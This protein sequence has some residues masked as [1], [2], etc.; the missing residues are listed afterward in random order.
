ME[1]LL[2]IPIFI[3][4]LL[5]IIITPKW[6]RK[7]NQTG[8]LWEDMNKF[9][10]PKNIASSGGIIV[11]ISFVLGVF[12][13]VAL[14]V[15]VFNV[16]SFNLEIFALLSSILILAIVGLTDDLL[17]WKNGGLSV[18]FRLFLILFASIPLVVINAG[19][20]DV[21]LPFFNQINLGIWYPL[22]FIPLG[23]I[24][25]TA[26]YNILAGFNGL[27]TSQG[28]IIL[29]FLSYISYITG[30][31]WLAIVGLCM[32]A[33]LIGFYIFNKF[34]AAVFPGDILTY[35]VGALVAI[36]AILGNFEKIAVFVFI[37]YILETGLKLRGKLKKQSFAIPNADGSLE[38]PY[39]KIYSL[40][41]LAI[42]I[43]KKFK[44]KVYEQDVV[45]LINA[46]QILIILIS[47]F[48]F[49]SYIFS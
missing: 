8:L 29:G 40:N 23:I 26:T 5:T 3:S 39:K 49:K 21:N 13:Y 11:V 15:F 46:F 43:L 18:R 19:H 12:I 20:H 30:S 6:I 33:S 35:S 24:G 1:P 48:L 16:M 38:M 36:M 37:P 22:F 10:H 47:L 44:N 42:L 4:L 7:C 2:L 27:E 9:S 31:P 45:Y 25:A 28:I 32:V 14:K 17:G 34:P 41:H